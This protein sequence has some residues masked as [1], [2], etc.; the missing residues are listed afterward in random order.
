[1]EKMSIFPTKIVL[2]AAVVWVGYVLFRGRCTPA[3]HL[4][5]V[6]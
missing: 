2:D 5:C 4:E 3:E 1:M 6:R